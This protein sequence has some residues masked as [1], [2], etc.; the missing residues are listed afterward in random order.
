MVTTMMMPGRK[1]QKEA[2]RQQPA[3]YLLQPL[4][5]GATLPADPQAS[6]AAHHPVRAIEALGNE[7]CVHQRADKVAR[8]A[9]GASRA[10]AGGCK[11]K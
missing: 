3:S 6:S 7:A 1:R 2:N 8:R 9:R 5:L 4:A 11:E 10:S